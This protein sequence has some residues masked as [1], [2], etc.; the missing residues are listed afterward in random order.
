MEM[1]LK[2][3]MMLPRPDSCQGPSCRWDVDAKWA[4]HDM[5]KKRPTSSEPAWLDPSNDRKTPYTDV[6]LD[7]LTDDHIAMMADT[8]AWRN[9]VADLGKQRAREF[10]KMRLAGRDPNSLINWQPSGPVH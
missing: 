1:A 4:G 9:L 6:E 5:E 2:N 10:V 8:A 7:R 3:M